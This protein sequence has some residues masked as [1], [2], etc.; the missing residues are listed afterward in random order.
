[1]SRLLAAHYE[2]VL[3]TLAFVPLIGIVLLYLYA[4]RLTW[5]Y[6]Y[7]LII[8][9]GWGLLFADVL[10]MQ[11][12]AVTYAPSA[13]LRE[14][15]ASEDGASTVFVYLFGWIVPLVA[16]LLLDMLRWLWR[17]FAK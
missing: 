10:L 15:A 11:H 14:H 9:L 7:T 3:N 5:A 17:F 6:R 16:T 13:R 4:I 1:M 2:S 8:L 12:L